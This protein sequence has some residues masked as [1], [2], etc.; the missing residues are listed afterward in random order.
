MSPGQVGSPEPQS[1]K[2]PGLPSPDKENELATTTG[3]LQTLKTLPSLSRL[4]PR[5]TRASGRWW[6][7]CLI[8]PNLVSQDWG[9]GR[10]MRRGFLPQRKEWVCGELGSQ[11][12]GEVGLLLPPSL[13]V[14]FAPT[15]E[16]NTTM[17]ESSLLDLLPKEEK[18]R[19]YF[20]YLGSLTT[21]TCDEKV[22]WTVFQEPIQLH[23]EQVHRA[24]GRA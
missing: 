7:H 24:R 23:R 5:R 1:Q 4:D 21:P 22:V 12:A 14:S 9:E 10:G 6:R 11:S 2:L 18:L 3:S 13:T 20:R 8:S 17:A 16:M 19:N 15:P